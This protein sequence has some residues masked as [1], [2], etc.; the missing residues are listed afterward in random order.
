MVSRSGDARGAAMSG[1]GVVL[2]LLRRTSPRMWGR[3]QRRTY[4][5]GGT[6][7]RGRDSV[8]DSLTLHRATRTACV[9]AIAV[10]QYIGIKGAG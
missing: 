10:W 7:L 2:S 5:V 8:R 3:M 6:R 4:I 1:T 9:T